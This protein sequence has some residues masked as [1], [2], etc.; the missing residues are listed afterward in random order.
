MEEPF[1]ISTSFSLANN[2]ESSMYCNQSNRLSKYATN[3]LSHKYLFFG[4]YA[5]LA[6]KWFYD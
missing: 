5:A 3:G 6:I 2:Q 4:N 1:G